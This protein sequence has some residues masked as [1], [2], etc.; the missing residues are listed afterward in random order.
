M[1]TLS[2]TRR[3]EI[4]LALVRHQVRTQRLR[5]SAQAIKREIGQ[6]SKDIG[7]PPEELQAFVAQLLEEVLEELRQ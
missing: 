1:T 7:I 5:L 2:E 3:G 4:A 6:L